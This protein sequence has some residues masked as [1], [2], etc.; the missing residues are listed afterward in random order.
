ME[1]DIVPVRRGAPT[2]GWTMAAQTSAR[3][4][5]FDFDGTL[6]RQDTFFTYC[7]AI[8][9]R[10]DHR[11]RAMMEVVRGMALVKARMISNHQLKERCVAALLSGEQERHVDAIVRSESGDRLAGRLDVELVGL[12]RRIQE[13]GANV[14]L[15]SSNLDCYLRPLGELWGLRGVIATR[16]EVVDGRFT[17]RLVGATC[18]GP[19]KVARVIEAVGED[20]ART[21]AAF[22]DSRGDE[23][24]LNYV[25]EGY[26][27]RRRLPMR[28]SS[29]E[30]VRKGGAA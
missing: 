21:G 26:W 7:L 17:G 23:D 3:H 4:V 19:E 20:E 13:A 16:T 1:T 30:R 2:D 6:T 8:A 27:I 15:V 11:M 24:L 10:N 28:R 22:G 5:F 29:V 9:R 12:L 25:N 18:I 14:F